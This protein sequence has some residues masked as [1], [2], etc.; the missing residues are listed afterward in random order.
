MRFTTITF[1]LMLVAASF[2]QVNTSHQN[3]LTIY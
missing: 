1:E 3:T 2:S